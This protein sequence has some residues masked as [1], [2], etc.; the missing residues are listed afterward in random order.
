[1][2]AKICHDC[3]SRPDGHV[4]SDADAVRNCAADADLTAI[5]YPHI[6]REVSTRVDVYAVGQIAVVVDSCAGVDDAGVTHARAY[7]HDRTGNDKAPA[8]HDNV[9][10]HDGAGVNDCRDPQ[11]CRLQTPHPLQPVPACPPTH[12]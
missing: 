3:G 7:V 6:T 2:I 4:R 9:W 10:R 8:A 1:M 12:R 5:S 11:S